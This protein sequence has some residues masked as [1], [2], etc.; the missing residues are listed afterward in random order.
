M[1]GTI[2]IRIRAQGFSFANGTTTGAGTGAGRAGRDVR[3]F[4]CTGR[5]TCR[6]TA[7]R[8]RCATVRVRA[9]GRLAL[10]APVAGSGAGG[11][12][13]TA[14]GVGVGTVVVVSGGGADVVVS[15]SGTGVVGGG[16]VDEVWAGTGTVGGSVTGGP[17]VEAALV[18]VVGRRPGGPGSTMVPAWRL[19]WSRMIAASTS[20][21]PNA[22]VH[23][24][25]TRWARSEPSSS[26]PLCIGADIGSPLASPSG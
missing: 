26:V 10:G 11:P 19:R 23:P 20:S 2:V 1:G 6:R 18:D 9:F 17:V 13:G 4:A 5:R 25:T 16:A 21:T 14:P 8:R 7:V 24:R 15:G 3:R 12:P 22:S